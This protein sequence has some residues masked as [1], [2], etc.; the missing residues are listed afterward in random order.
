MATSAEGDRPFPR[1]SVIILASI[2]TINSY[3]LANLFPYVGMMVKYIMGLST[4]NE[5]GES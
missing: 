5:S 1:R 2:L 3:T 4:I